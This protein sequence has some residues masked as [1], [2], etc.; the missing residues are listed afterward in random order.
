MT[1][2]VPIA[3]RI[4]KLADSYA[5]ALKKQVDARMIE[6]ESDDKAHYLIYGVLGISAHEGN[7]IDLYQNKGRFLYK[8]AGTFLENAVKMCFE[9]RFSDATSLRIPNTLGSRPKTFQI[10]CLVGNEAYEI[11]WRDA[12]TD[13]DH[14]MKEHTRLKVISAGNFTPIRLMFYYPNRQQA[15]KIQAIL[16]DLYKV[17]GGMY[18]HGNAAWEHLKLKSGVDLLQILEQIAEKRGL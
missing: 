2:Y 7:Q 18:Y 17:V 13:G 8:Y 6:M 15:I 3:E 12:T 1:T 4:S 9:E 11:K 14:I 10:D 16:A 5:A